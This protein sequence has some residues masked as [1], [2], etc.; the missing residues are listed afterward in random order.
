[1]KK[2]IL[3]IAI[4]LIGVAVNAQ[5]KLLLKGLISNNQVA[6]LNVKQFDHELASPW[7]PGQRNGSTTMLF[8]VTRN[9]DGKSAKLEDASKRGRVL[10]SG[11]VWMKDFNGTL[12]KFKLTN[13]IV[14]NYSSH[15]EN[16]KPPVERFILAYENMTPL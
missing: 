13:I 8:Q 12:K 1:M 2:F 10:S 15:Y 5:T 6:T 4:M 11:Q 3:L 7:K 9:M 16:G 14:Y